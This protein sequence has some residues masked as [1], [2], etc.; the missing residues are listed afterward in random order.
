MKWSLLCPN[1]FMLLLNKIDKVNDV[2]L[3]E[4]IYGIAMC[5][6]YKSKDYDIVRKI[7]HIIEKNFFLDK[8]IKTYDFQIRTY[9]RDIAQLALKMNIID[10]RQVEKYLPPYNC[11]EMIN[12][13]LNAAK[14]GTRMGG[15]RSIEYDLARYVLC[16]HISYRFFDEYNC[17]NEKDN[18]VKIQDVFSKEEL[19]KYKK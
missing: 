16:D 1:E 6:C 2:Q 19:E 13:N 4:Q 9:I 14:E 7:L 10:K 11:N 3:L 8:E 12:L 18:E 5:L 15:Y 17:C